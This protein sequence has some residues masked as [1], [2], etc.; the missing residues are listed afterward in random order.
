M[1]K[2]DRSPINYRKL[3]RGGGFFGDLAGGLAKTAMGALGEENIGDLAQ[4]AIG[5]L[6]GDEDLAQM[7]KD[8]LGRAQGGLMDK[9]GGFINPGDSGDSGE[10][11]GG[12][13]GGGGDILGGVP[14]VDIKACD[15]SIR[16]E[17]PKGPDGCGKHESPK[18]TVQQLKQGFIDEGQIYQLDDH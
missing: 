8:I 12:G 13:G 10:G 7:G 18:P 14:S 15:P 11:E 16:P 2:I 9:I 6:G 1:V 3:Q 17:Y 5:A 4:T